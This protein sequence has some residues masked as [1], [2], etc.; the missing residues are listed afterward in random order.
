MFHTRRDFETR[1]E[2][3]SL[4]FAFNFLRIFKLPGLEDEYI[5]HAVTVIRGGERS[6][7][8]ISALRLFVRH[9]AY[10]ASFSLQSSCG[11]EAQ[12]E[13]EPHIFEV[14]VELVF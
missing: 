6:I 14:E 8:R 7:N 11:C 10:F 1:Y 3:L 2:R 5:S 9:L 12:A 13:H 4:G